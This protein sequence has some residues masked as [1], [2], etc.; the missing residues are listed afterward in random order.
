MWSLKRYKWDYNEEIWR[1]IKHVLYFYTHAGKR[2]EWYSLPFTICLIIHVMPW[3]LYV[4]VIQWKLAGK[5]R[6]FTNLTRWMHWL[7]HH[8]IFQV[9]KMATF[10]I[11]EGFFFRLFSWSEISG[12]QKLDLHFFKNRWSIYLFTVKANE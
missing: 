4:F 10:Q 1:I 5:K 2:N 6:F 9:I 12:K 8:H 7:S 11:F 3:N